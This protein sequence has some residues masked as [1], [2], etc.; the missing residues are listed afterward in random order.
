M[1]KRIIR[2]AA[3]LAVAAVALSS[4]ALTDWDGDVLV[5]IRHPKAE[6]F[7][8]GGGAT[9]SGDVVYRNYGSPRSV[10]CVVRVR[11]RMVSGAIIE[12]QAP[13]TEFV[14][15]SRETEHIRKTITW[16]GEARE[17]QDPKLVC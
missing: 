2:T 1:K 6:E 4:C 5:K 14:S 7:R 17:L 3:V 9:L 8:F 12:R 10:R 15:G 16:P 13:V 11:V